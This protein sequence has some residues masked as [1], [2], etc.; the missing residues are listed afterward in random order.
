MTSKRGTE[1]ADEQQEVEG[2]IVVIMD[3][4]SS[5]ECRMIRMDEI[6]EAF[7]RMERADVRCRIVV[8]RASPPDFAGATA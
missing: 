8:D 3:A 2:K 7:E 4:G 5:P 6:D 1:D